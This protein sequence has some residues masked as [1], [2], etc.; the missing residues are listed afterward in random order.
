MQH[1]E[2]LQKFFV[3]IPGIRAESSGG[4]GNS[5]ITVRGVPVSA[6]GS[7]YLLIQEDGLPVLQLEI[8][9]WNSRP[10]YKI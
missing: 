1:Q 3:T 5:N 8:S 2:Q 7:R 6:G 4:E 9:L 10:I